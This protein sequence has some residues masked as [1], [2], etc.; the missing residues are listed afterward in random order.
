MR[1]AN[2]MLLAGCAANLLAL[3]G[4]ATNLLVPAGCAANLL[5]LTGC[6]A[7]L[8]RFAVFWLWQQTQHDANRCVL[9]YAIKLFRNVRLAQT[10]NSSAPENVFK[11]A[12]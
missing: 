6:A 3:T 2:L 9:T 7:N 5:A 1:T 4:C 11:R 12:A 10:T 8:L